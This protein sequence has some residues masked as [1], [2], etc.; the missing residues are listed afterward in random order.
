MIQELP[1]SLQGPMTEQTRKT[2]KCIRWGGEE[3]IVIL[4]F[5]DHRKA[6][7]IAEKIRETMA[8]VKFN[9]IG[10][11]TLSVGVTESRTDDTP[12]SILERVDQRLYAAKKAGKNRITAD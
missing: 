10:Q 2:D 1:K 12:A 9:H 11:V 4:P 7:E 6:M 5:C 8:G 3:F